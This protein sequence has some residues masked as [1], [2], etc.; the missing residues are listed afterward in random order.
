MKLLLIVPLTALL[1]AGATNTNSNTNLVATNAPRVAVAAPYVNPA[2]AIAQQRLD[3][4]TARLDAIAAA[5]AGYHRAKWTAIER[6]NLQM[7]AGR[8]NAHQNLANAHRAEAEERRLVLKD[9]PEVDRLIL[10]QFELQQ[11]YDLKPT[12]KPKKKS[13]TAIMPLVGG[14][15]GTLGN[16]EKHRASSTRQK[17][18]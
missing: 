5:R 13:T 18:Q 1:C 14:K 7:R 2:R 4:I 10:Q 17:A 3:L 9:K 11:R 16:I 12:P 6:S 8:I 15:T